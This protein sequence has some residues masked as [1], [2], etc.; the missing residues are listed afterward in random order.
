MDAE[1]ANLRAAFRWATDRSD[2]VTAAA[3]AAHTAAMALWLLVLEPIGWA[4]ELLPAATT[5][6]IAQLPRLYTAAGL[7]GYVGRPEAGAEH[8]RTALRLA[9]ND[10]YDPFHPAYPGWVG[11]AEMVGGGDVDHYVDE[12]SAM[13]GYEAGR[14][15]VAADR[16]DLGQVIGLAG[17]AYMLPAVG[18]A[19]E[20]RAPAAQA[21]RVARA[22][23]NPVWITVTLLGVGR[24]FADTDP[25]HA[26]DAFAQAVILTREERIPWWEAFAAFESDGLE[27]LHGDPDTGL[28][29]FD[30]VITALHLAGNGTDPPV[31]VAALAVY[32][33]QAGQPET[34]ATLY[35][36]TVHAVTTW[37][38]AVPAT[39][40]HLRA[41]LGESRFDEC[42]A[43][44]AAME[45]GDA[46]AYAR[47]QIRA[48]RAA[49]ASTRQA[50]AADRSAS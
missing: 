48:A 4:E 19:E 46:V 29:L 28:D 22:H 41:A 45:L 20:A 38:P 50:Q 7:A 33:D 9:V 34:A 10:R 42:V 37:L 14:T 32:F 43:A 13:A 11:N 6:D 17:L 15:S 47:Q 21:L 12:M 31:A 5:T 8:A 35:G 23:A 2:L 16:S 3:I 40:E 18:R 49:L 26:L 1:L 39:L 44:G 25:P 27:T 30:A 24:A 36:T